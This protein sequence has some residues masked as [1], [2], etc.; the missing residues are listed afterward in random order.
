[1]NVLMNSLSVYLDGKNLV[2]KP[3]KSGTEEGGKPWECEPFDELVQRARSHDGNPAV[4]GVVLEDDVLLGVRLRVPVLRDGGH[5]Q[6]NALLLLL[7]VG[8]QHSVQDAD[9]LE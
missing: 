8:L 3:K 1:M 5:N 2:I 4:V 7:Q 6:G 9:V